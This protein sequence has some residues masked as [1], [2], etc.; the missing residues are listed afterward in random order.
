MREKNFRDLKDVHDQM[1]A[2][3]TILNMNSEETWYF[4]GWIQGLA[5]VKLWDKKSRTLS[6]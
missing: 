4:N 5:T 3:A 1:Q 2:D 6:V